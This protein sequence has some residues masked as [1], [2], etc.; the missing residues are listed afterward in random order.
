ML[1]P[2]VLLD[3]TA[4]TPWRRVFSV[5]Y[6]PAN[7]IGILHRQGGSLVRHALSGRPQA[8]WPGATGSADAG[9]LITFAWNAP[10]RRWAISLT[11]LDG[12]PV[13]TEG[14]R[15]PLPLSE[16]DAHAICATGAG[17][18]RI[19]PAVSWCGLQRGLFEMPPAGLIEAG[20]PI[21]TPAGTVA[22]GALRPGD[23]VLT[24]DHGPRPLT[25]VRT[26]DIPH[27]GSLAPVR[28][29]AG[30]FQTARDRTIGPNTRILFEGATVEYLFGI[31][32]V[33]VSGTELDDGLMGRRV[34]TPGAS[35]MVALQCANPELISTDAVVVLTGHCGTRAAPSPRPCLRSYE[36]A[37]LRADLIGL[38]GRSA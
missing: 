19:H 10:A 35:R 12:G 14:G 30:Q 6:D 3:F 2:T 15:A 9:A 1:H 24:R 26:M 5:L 27:R 17:S 31:D 33:L 21:R 28:L 37:A 18:A 29:R 4:P 32:E 38:A 16:A 23:L 13:R 22:A 8:T 25:G 7:G 34:L 11:P 36:T 20:A